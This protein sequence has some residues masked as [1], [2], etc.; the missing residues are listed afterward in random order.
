MLS[1]VISSEPQGTSTAS[2]SDAGEVGELLLLCERGE[3]GDSWVCFDFLDV[4]DLRDRGLKNHHQGLQSNTFEP[5]QKRARR[6]RCFASACASHYL[7]PEGL[8]QF[9]RRPLTRSS[10]F[11]DKWKNNHRFDN[12]VGT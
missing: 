8:G 1:S 6:P 2:R 11:F 5:K 12:D 7:A 3:Q 9:P 10:A 4:S